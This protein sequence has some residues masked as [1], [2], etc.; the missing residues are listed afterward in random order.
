MGDWHARSRR[1]VS[2]SQD[3]EGCALAYQL[4]PRH[5]RLWISVSYPLPVCLS[6]AWV[7]G[8]WLKMG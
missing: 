8:G 7:R 3:A 1:L 4:V 5:V 6:R 2:P